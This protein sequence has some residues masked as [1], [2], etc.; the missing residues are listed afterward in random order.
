LLTCGDQAAIPVS[1]KRSWPSPALSET[2]AFRLQ[3]S[4]SQGGQTVTLTREVVVLVTSPDVLAW[5][6]PDSVPY[7]QSVVLKWSST[8]ADGIYFF[9][10]Q[11]NKK[12]LG[13]A[14][15]P[16]PTHQVTVKPESD[17]TYS[18]QAFR[19][20]S[21]GPDQHSKVYQIAFTFAPMEIVC[22]KAEPT[23]FKT[24]GGTLSW[25][26]VGAK[27]VTLQ[28]QPVNCVDSQKVVPKDDTTYELVATW[29]D[30]TK[31]TKSLTVPVLKVQVTKVE[32]RDFNVDRSHSNFL[33]VA[34]TIVFDVN[35]ATGGRFHCSSPTNSEDAPME[36]ARNSSTQWTAFY[37]TTIPPAPTFSFPFNYSFQGDL[38]L[39]AKGSG[40]INETGVKWIGR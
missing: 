33:L 19:R 36:R 6:E 13:K 21:G 34:V 14:P 31:V 5:F 12:T 39:P 29:V 25:N 38:L 27:A 20:K 7:G 18:A 9:T 35:G 3:A 11:T 22:F 1:D 10:G 24:D 37:T 15:D 2:T 30:G 4:V 28:Q 8:H 16:D 32:A 23:S 26:V 40:E 17:T